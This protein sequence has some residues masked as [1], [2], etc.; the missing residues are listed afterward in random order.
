MN[1]TIALYVHV[2]FCVRRCPYCAFYSVEEA[3]PNQLQEYP[4]LLLSELRLRAPVWREL[5][6]ASIYLGGGTPTLLNPLAVGQVLQGIRD[7]FA[8]LPEVEISLEANPGTITAESLRGY[9]QAGI[10]R[11]SLGLQAL[12]DK[13]LKFLGR[14]H[15]CRQAL[16]ALEAARQADF[17][18]ISVDL[19]VGTQ[20]ENIAS[21][22]QEFDMLLPFQPG[23]VSFY[24]LTVEEGTRLARRCE[25]GERVFLPQEETVDL[26]LHAAERLRT[27][28]YRHYEVSNW[29][30]PGAESRHNRHYWQRGKYL[31][32]GPSAHSFDGTVRS[33]NLPDLNIYDA[34]LAAGRL[35][36]GESEALGAE[37]MRTEYVY[38]SLRQDQGLDFGEYQEHF[39]KVPHYW[40]G[41]FEAIASKG[42]GIFD[43]VRFQ[44]NDQGLLLA[45]EIAARILA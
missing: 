45:D 4:H 10:N 23:G 3:A 15:D 6:V 22:D 33:W 14:I 21:W 44:P 12:D 31:G 19:M 27:A 42:L 26:L 40:K 39:K 13:R 25:N 2:P 24:S 28:G 36:P 5:P 16:A 18:S 37:E 38:L 17:D 9:V 1:Q 32:L 8:C 41:M 35:P 30:L 11:L 29:A 43:G 34:A 20:R 7:E